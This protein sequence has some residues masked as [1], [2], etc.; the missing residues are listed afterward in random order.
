MSRRLYT[1]MIN[2]I[3]INNMMNIN[4]R[5]RSVLRS[6]FLLSILIGVCAVMV[7]CPETTIT[8]TECGI[9]GCLDCYTYEGD[10]LCRTCA[11]GFVE[12]FGTCR[13]T[14]YLCPGGTPRSGNPPGNDDFEICQSCNDDYTLGDDNLCRRFS[15]T[16][17]TENEY[18]FDKANVYV[19]GVWGNDTTLWVANDNR[20]PDPEVGNTITAYNIDTGRE[21]PS[22]SFTTLDAAGNHTPRG[23]WSD[24]TTM[25]VI[26]A[27]DLRIY[28]YNLETKEREDSANEIELET[29]NSNNIENN[30]NPIDL[31]SDG[32]IMWVSDSDDQRLYAYNVGGI[33]NKTKNIS[34]AGSASDDTHKVFPGGIWS[35]GTTMWVNARVFDGTDNLVRA[36]VL[37]DGARDA[38]NDWNIAVS[39]LHNAMWSDGATDGAT[40][41]ST[42][43]IRSTVNA[44]TLTTTTTVERNESGDIDANRNSFADDIWIEGDTLWALDSFD[45]IIYAYT[46]TDD[47]LVYNAA[48]NFETLIAAGNMDGESITVHDG[49]MQVLDTTDNKIYAYNIG[50]KARE[51]NND[52]DLAGIEHEYIAHWI[53][54]GTVWVIDN[55]PA[56]NIHGYSLST[57]NRDTGKDIQLREGDSFTGGDIWTDGRIMW[58][59][60][61]NGPIRAFDMSNGLPVPSNN[62]SSTSG[63]GMWSDGEILRIGPDLHR[64]S[65]TAYQ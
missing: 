59:L 7:S 17:V 61:L 63:F 2:V 50:T 48:E 36:F 58:V 53:N 37:N 49:A 43:W 16:R 18:I 4:I 11:S 57:G 44:Y 6:L 64:P 39:D 12:V 46:I 13:S 29:N 41:W 56:Q 15:N 32:S 47:G 24:G 34:V 26:D 25:W 35:D 20:F 60:D 27:E 3:N 54:D 14:R 45:D 28:A 30:N 9:T 31:W 8:P 22:Q 55:A 21:D 19:A 23:I 42:E 1:K 5:M 38:S 40:L 51:S 52:I 10:N 65:I 62:I 33:Y